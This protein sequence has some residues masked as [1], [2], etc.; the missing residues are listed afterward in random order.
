MNGELE[1]K[2]VAILA[3]NG[4]EE[5][6][7]TSPREALQEAGAK[8]FIVS[9]ESG[10]IKSWH[11]NNWG[12]DFEVDVTLDKADEASFDGLVL[13]GGVMNPDQLRMNEDA[14]NFIRAFFKSGKPVSAICHGPQ[15]LIDADVLQGREITSYPSIKNDIKNAG[16]RWVDN[17]VVVDKGL[18][19]SRT[20]EDLS[21]FN[22]KMVEELREGV[23]DKQM[24]A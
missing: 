4:F 18:T 1:G 6:E 22:R 17:E 19:T 16:A 11:E 13:P 9:P 10:T 14:L 20:P 21:A 2:N 5:S 3:T 15:L 23:H 7:L 12:G 8:T 24:T